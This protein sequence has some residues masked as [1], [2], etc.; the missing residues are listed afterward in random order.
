MTAP[1]PV[2]CVSAL[3][4]AP[5]RTAFSYLADSSRLGEWALGCWEAEPTGNGVVRGTSLL[6][7]GATYARVVPV[8][9]ALTVDFEVGAEP[10]RLVRRISA[11]VV[12][13]GDVEQDSDRSLVML[14]AWRTASMDDERWHRLAATHEAEILLLRGRIERSDA[15]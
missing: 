15:A 1:A 7:G 11:R 9:D 6:D 14:L 12:A 13:G 2:H 10:E 4:D 5:A 8:E 3:C